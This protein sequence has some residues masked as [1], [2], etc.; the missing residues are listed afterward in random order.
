[1][2]APHIGAP[3]GHQIAFNWLAGKRFAGGS[4]IAQVSC[5]KIKIQNMA[6]E[7]FG[8]NA[9][10]LQ[11]RNQRDTQQQTRQ[12]HV[13]SP[14]GSKDAQQARGNRRCN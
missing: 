8:P 10:F 6:I 5:F 4:P 3:F 12:N 13:P 11:R 9:T 7:P 1:M 2:L 14:E